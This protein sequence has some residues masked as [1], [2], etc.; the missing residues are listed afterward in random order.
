MHY[1]RYPTSARAYLTEHIRHVPAVDLLAD[2]PSVSF[3][4]QFTQEQPFSDLAGGAALS[5]EFNDLVF[6]L[7][8]PEWVFRRFL[9]RDRKVWVRIGFAVA[10]LLNGV[11]QHLTAGYFQHVGVA[12]ELSHVEADVCGL[13]GGEDDD[14]HGRIVPFAFIDQVN[15][16]LFSKVDVE[17]KQVE[18]FFQQKMPERCAVLAAE[19]ELYPRIVGEDGAEAF[20]E[21]GMVVKNPGAHGLHGLSG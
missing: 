3:D 14:P 17:E 20:H 9:R 18:S 21:E 2:V 5:D 1:H 4:S 13:M 15:A 16:V 8:E 10:D 12:A 19:Y 11:F 6:P 7:G